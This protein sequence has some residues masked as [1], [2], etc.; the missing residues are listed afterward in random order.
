MQLNQPD[1]LGIA[2]DG[3]DVGHWHTHGR[4]FDGNQNQLV[5]VGDGLESDDLAVAVRGLDVP[6]SGAAPAV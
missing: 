5:L 4:A 1:A 3:S 6:D 2:A